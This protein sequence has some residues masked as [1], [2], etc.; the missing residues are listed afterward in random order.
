MAR[1]QGISIAILSLWVGW[2]L[3]MWFAATRSFRTA[4]RVL[5]SPPPEFRRIVQSLGPE[6][7]RGVL[8]YLASE[9]NRT[10]FRAYGWGQIVLG[11]VLLALVWLK[12]PRDSFTLVV[13]ASMLFIVLVLTL[14]VMPQIIAL[15]RNI[16]FLPRTP[17]PPDYQRFWKL[18]AIFTGLD[19]VKLL[20]GIA[21]L[22]RLI[23]FR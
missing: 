2:T 10:Y 14:G 8:R 20:A 9:I 17:A 16:D 3:F 19:G 12:T 15:G 6:H 21:L 23:A 7:T 11:S 13:S 5:N 22:V 18:H 1:V 4:D